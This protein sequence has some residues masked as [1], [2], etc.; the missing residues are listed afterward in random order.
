MVKII[1]VLA[2][3]ENIVKGPWVTEHHII[4]TRCTF[5]IFIFVCIYIRNGELII[6]KGQ[7]IVNHQRTHFVSPIV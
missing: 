6:R 1:Y 2:T 5:E 7:W 3:I 4:V